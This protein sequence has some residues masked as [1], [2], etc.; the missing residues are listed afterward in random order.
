MGWRA[1]EYYGK[2]SRTA[3]TRGGERGGNAGGNGPS[4]EFL[5]RLMP[6]DC[7]KGRMR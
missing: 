1:I 4:L 5:Q 3:G 2:V 7:G 6:Y